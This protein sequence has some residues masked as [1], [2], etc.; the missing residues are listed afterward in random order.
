MSKLDRESLIQDNTN[1]QITFGY[2]T[3]LVFCNFGKAVACRPLFHVLHTVGAKPEPVFVCDSTES[4]NA[5]A[6]FEASLQRLR[7]ESNF[8]FG[9]LFVGT[10]ISTIKKVTSTH[11]QGANDREGE[12]DAAGGDQ[13]DR[14]H[15]KR[16]PMVESPM[17]IYR[18]RTKDRQRK[19]VFELCQKSFELKNIGGPYSLYRLCRTWVHGRD[20][21]RPYNS[22]EQKQDEEAGDGSPTGQDGEPKPE[23]PVFDDLKSDNEESPE[24]DAADVDMMLRAYIPYWKQV[25]RNANRESRMAY[26]EY[27]KSFEALKTM[28]IPSQGKN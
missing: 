1:M 14:L 21:C 23:V 12:N 3:T 16:D 4:K 15:A 13:N 17:K 27:H 10:T 26:Q 22:Q 6:I 5:S 19:V 18:K 2:C 8:E 25:K 11:R 9:K 28:Y 20:D 7:D 24:K